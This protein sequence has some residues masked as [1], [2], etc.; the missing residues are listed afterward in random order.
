MFH[1]KRMLVLLTLCFL[2]ICSTFFSDRINDTDMTNSLKG[3]GG[4]IPLFFSFIFFYWLLRDRLDLMYLFLW[5][6]AISF[7]VS[8]FV[9]VP[10]NLEDRITQEGGTLMDTGSL[11]PRLVAGAIGGFVTVFS[12]RFYPKH[13]YLICVVRLINSFYNLLKGSRGSFMLGLT[14]TLLLLLFA[15]YSKMDHLTPR[16][17]SNVKRK[18]PAAIIILI[19]GVF[20]ARHIYSYAAEHGYMGEE[21]RTKYE[22]QSS[23]KLGLLSGR[24]EFVA[25]SLAIADA[26]WLGHGSYAMDEEGYAYEAAELT[27]D[28]I[29]A[30]YAKK[31]ETYIPTH[32]HLTG[33]WVQSGIFG[34]LFWLYALYLTLTFLLKYSYIYPK[35][36]G[37]ILPMSISII[38]TIL[39]SPF[40]NRLMLGAFF[41]FIIIMMD[42][43]DRIYSP[44]T[45]NTS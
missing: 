9:F 34:A 10:S 13:P 26:P 15:R 2:W 18:I 32:S 43:I 37:Y 12:F 25:A 6:A 21:Q 22:K 33:A 30:A 36:L 16:L 40:Q 11:W 24:G 44:K 3:I 8:L 5:G 27:G 39:F 7:V 1:N 31:G 41:A 38:W 17:V 4:I 29:D 35:Y 45:Y 20:V 28:D 19:I 14:N 42:Q 23:S